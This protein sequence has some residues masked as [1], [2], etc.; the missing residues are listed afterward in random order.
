MNP[1]LALPDLRIELGGTAIGASD[2]AALAEVRVRQRLSLPSQCELVF[3]EPLSLGESGSALR[4]G[5]TL[6]LQI[7]GMDPALF[8]GEVTAIDY[9]YGPSGGRSVRI[10]AYDL[11]HRLRKRQ[12]VRLHV[13]MSA[14]DLARELVADLGVSVEAP[15]SGPLHDR[16]FQVGLS[17]LDLVDRTARRAGLYFVLQDE[18]FRLF[19][20]SGLG[21]SHKLRIGDTLLEARLE[22][23]GDPACRSVATQGWDP[24]RAETRRGKASGARTGRSVSTEVAPTDVG[25]SGDRTRLN[26]AVGND[27]QADAL[28]QAE[29]DLAVAR[30]VTLWG[31]AEGDPALRPGCRVDLEGVTPTLEGTYVLCSVEHRI[32]PEHGFIS[33]IGTLPPPPREESPATVAALGQVTQVDDPEKLG[34]VRV[35]LPA[36]G[37]LETGWIEVLVP[38]AGKSKG[39]VALPGIGDRVLLLFPDGDPAQAL[40]AGG[41]YGPDGPPDS[42]VEGGSMRRYTFTTS[43]GQKLQLDDAGRKLRLEDQSGSYLELGPE[44]AILHAAVDL[45]LEAPG[46]ALRIRSHSVD[47]EQV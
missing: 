26:V 36:L 21:D 29:L 37:E 27:R 32:D 44:R 34:R 43:G 40:V 3:Q 30:E 11:L 41:L 12:P 7:S 22:V 4:P 1:V 17:D 5:A 15:D 13:Q 8:S 35:S 28:A 14:A 20:L 10:R 6:L 23:N 31:V 19:T 33:E 45:T 38:G 24:A 42:G 39:L 9:V 46:H 25:G 18:S 16:I 47:F 2:A